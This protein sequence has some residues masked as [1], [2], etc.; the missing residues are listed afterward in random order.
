VSRAAAA[1]ARPARRRPGAAAQPNARHVDSIAGVVSGAAEIELAR[2][3][4]ATRLTHLYQHDPLR[5]LFP[6]PDPGDAA[7]AVLVTTSGGLVAGDRI[8]IDVRVGPGA[9]AHVTTSAAEKVYRST[10]A[11]TQ[12][13]QSITVGPGACLEYLPQETILFDSARLRRH[14][15][16]NVAPGAGFL[17]GGMIVFGRRARGEGFTGS[18]LHERL[19]IGCDRALAWGDALHLDGDV[20]RLMADPACLAGAAACATLVLVPP[21]GDPVRFVEPARGVQRQLAAP[22]LRAGVTAVNGVAVTRWLSADAAVLRRAFV[23]LAC[24]WRQAALGL[25]ARL[26]RLWHN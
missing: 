26:P 24:H 16:V 3:G 13:A 10:G 23:D 4:E 11:T 21:R 22:G 9:V 20:A 7:L 19:E 12:I 5:V 14:T 1:A 15:I 6:T 25:P 17:G 2:K 18:L 8:S